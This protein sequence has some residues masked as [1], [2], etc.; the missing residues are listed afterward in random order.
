[1]AG[2]QFEIVHDSEALAE[3]LGRLIDTVERPGVAMQ[4]IA[5]FLMDRYDERFQ[6]QE[7]PWGNPWAALQPE[8]AA[9]KREGYY[10][11][12]KPRPVP[13]PDRILHGLSLR[14]RDSRVMFSSDTE[15]GLQL[16]G[17]VAAY[18]AT[19]QFG[20]PGRNIPARPVLGISDEDEVEILDI[21]NEEIL[22]AL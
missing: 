7:D 4:Q 13:H 17:E 3:V 2:S 21:L 14:F 18:A 1:M 6:A 8:T 10:A 9:Q 5:K 22:G 19:H 11:L 15:A 12:G 16:G 20:D